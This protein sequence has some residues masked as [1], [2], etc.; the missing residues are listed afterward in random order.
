M[1]E[2]MDEEELK[3]EIESLRD[4]VNSLENMLENLMTMHENVLE[5][6]SAASEVEK[7][8]MKI[9]STYKKFGHISPAQFTDI[10]DPISE[11]IVEILF[12]NSP[13]NITQIT[14]RLREKKG[15]AS[16]HTV[17]KKL[18]ELEEKNVVKKTEEEKKGKRY[19]L[20]EET[21]NKWAELLGINK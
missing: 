20:T 4:Q 3:E 14:G 11:K 19:E 2:E 8:Y 5:K 21:I 10:K 16:R 1:T 6:A 12:D 17:R 7:K 15:S 18:K 9:L 13:L